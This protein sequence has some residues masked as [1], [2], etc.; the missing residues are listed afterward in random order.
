M[1]VWNYIYTDLI[2]PVIDNVLNSVTV[3]CGEDL[4]PAAIGRPTA[5]DNEDLNPRLVYTDVPLGCA[6]TRMWTATDSAGNIAT[7]SQHI[8]IANPQPPVVTSPNQVLV[9]CGSIEDASSNL[10]H[11]NISVQHPCNRPLSFRFSDSANI[12]Q[13]GFTFSREWVVGDD[14]GLSIVFMQVIRVLDQQFP[15]G[16][17]NGLVNAGLNEPL[18]WPQFPGATSYEVYVWTAGEEQPTEPTAITTDRQYVPPSN[19]PPGTRILWRIEYVT[20]VDMTVPSPIWGFET[21]PHPDLQVTDVT[22]PSFAFSGQTFTVSW[23]VLNNGNLSVTVLSFYDSIYMGHSAAFSDSRRV[24]SVQQRR[25]LDVNDGY[26]SVAEV[27]L[28]NDDIGLFYVFVFTD[29]FFRVSVLGCTLS[30]HVPSVICTCFVI[31]ISS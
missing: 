6:L 22:V 15:D 16:P 17:V 14:C 31:S 7:S 26:T 29:T 9:T 2:P 27:N 25:F 24:H 11:N 5:A 12:T 18:S 19:Y 4:S 21:E 3:N 28:A 23:T 30:V 10:A 1:S 8:Q 13:C 20:G